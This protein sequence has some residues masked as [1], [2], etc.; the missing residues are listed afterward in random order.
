M[1]T[2]DGAAS[3][4]IH[5]TEMTPDEFEIE[6]TIDPEEISWQDEKGIWHTEYSEGGDRPEA[7]VM[8]GE[9]GSTTH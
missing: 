1:K 4:P 5:A 8:D 3:S 7:E 6:A 9:E 2:T